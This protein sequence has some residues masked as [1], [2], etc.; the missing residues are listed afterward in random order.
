MTRPRFMK[1]L[2]SLSHYHSVVDL[3]STSN[4]SIYLPATKDCA[5]R[6]ICKKSVRSLAVKLRVGALQAL[7]R[8]FIQSKA[9]VLES[10]DGGG[11]FL[12]LLQL[13]LHLPVPRLILCPF[14]YYRLSS[15]WTRP[16]VVRRPC[17]RL[18][19]RGRAWPGK[20]VSILRK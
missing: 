19:R 3:R 16:L 15:S 4:L 7:T 13:H 1:D 12:L 6:S 14:S 5:I 9:C 8:A 10:D 2:L 20:D 18:L 17:S 11:R